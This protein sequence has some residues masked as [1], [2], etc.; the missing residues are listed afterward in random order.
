MAEEGKFMLRLSKSLWNKAESSSA[1][2]ANSAGAAAAAAA[3]KKPEKAVLKKN[4]SDECKDCENIALAGKEYCI[5]C[6]IK[7]ESGQDD[8]G[9]SKSTKS[10]SSRARKTSVLRFGKGGVVRGTFAEVPGKGDKVPSLKPEECSKIVEKEMEYLKTLVKLLPQDGRHKVVKSG[11]GETHTSGEVV[12]T[13]SEISE[14]LMKLRLDPVH[15][16]IRPVITKF[17]QHPRNIGGSLTD[18]SIWATQRW[19]TT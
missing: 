12:M 2:S 16:L 4:C 11:E 17:M 1:T 10:S 5:N 15:R 7:R 6:F 14:H 13:Y 9:T 18:Q 19:R 3:L 8:G